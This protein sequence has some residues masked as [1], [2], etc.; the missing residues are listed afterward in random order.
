MTIK[1]TLALAL[2][3]LVRNKARSL[4]TMLG[5]VIGV[6][7]VIVTV[8]I[9]VGAR[10]S[11]RASKSSARWKGG[12]GRTGVGPD[13]A[14]ASTT[15]AARSRLDPDSVRNVSGDGWLCGSAA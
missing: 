1:A 14:G 10:T 9:G 3:A 11:V 8:A 7:A 4:L 2:A 12:S 13:D 5:I 15:G 6:A